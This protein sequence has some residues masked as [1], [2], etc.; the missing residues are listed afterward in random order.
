MSP[1]ETYTP[2][3]L[4]CPVSPMVDNCVWRVAFTG[5]LK[6]HSGAFNAGTVT[7]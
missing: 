2:G 3:L 6:P 4:V 5:P 1:S 7:V